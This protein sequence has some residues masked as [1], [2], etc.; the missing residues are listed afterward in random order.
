AF[1]IAGP[2]SRRSVTRCRRRMPFGRRTLRTLCNSWTPA[3]AAATLIACAPSPPLFDP[4]PGAEP[5]PAQTVGAI[6]AAWTARD[7][8]EP[9]HTRHLRPDGSPRYTN[10]LL[11]ETSP[12][13]RQHAHN[14][15]N[16]YPWGDEAFADARRLGRPVLLS[17]GYSTC[18]W[19]HV[20]EEESFEDEEIARV[21]NE[22]YVAIKVD[23][24]QRPDLDS[25]YMTAV[26][27]ATGGGGWPMTVWLTPAREPFYAGT[28]FPARDGD[29]GSSPGFLSVLEAVEKTWRTRA[30]DVAG[31]AA[32]LS[33]R[34]RGELAASSSAQAEDV[35]IAALAVDALDK[36]ASDARTRYDPEN[37]GTRGAR[38]FPTGLPLRPM[39]RYARRSGDADALAMVTNTLEHMAAGG[40]H[41][42]LAGGFH[43]YSV[44]P[45][46]RVPHFEKMLYDNALLA[47]T[48]TEASQA[49]GRA[50]FAAVAHEIVA[51]V[52][53]EMTA[54]DGAFYSATDADSRAPDGKLVE[55]WFFTWTAAET[56]A[57]LGERDA[58]LFDAAYGVRASGT[59][60]D[61]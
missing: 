22:R 50:D 10:R 7:A 48:Y 14:P 29:R 1:T 51:W 52:G 38:K 17:I 40:I 58:R 18:H 37:G 53:R 39:L 61:G 44:D 9:P 13:L 43:R 54:P 4:L 45:A 5:L 32:D 31:A 27:A 2:S 20:M 30:D 23:R 57:A 60:G 28:Y 34:V 35:D 59:S 19:C 12:Y 49:T 56:G 47:M 3:L 8:N 42:H 26:I 33:S 24:E 46:W 6:R 41:D 15:V 16:W 55:G 36:A 11:L 21:L 25:I